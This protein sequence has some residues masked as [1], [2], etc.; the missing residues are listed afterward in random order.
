MHNE[1]APRHHTGAPGPF[2]YLKPRCEL[3]GS[4]AP[5][6][7]SPGSRSPS[8]AARSEFRGPPSARRPEIPGAWPRPGRRGRGPGGLA[9]VRR[10]ARAAKCYAPLSRGP[11]SRRPHDRLQAAS[12]MHP[13]RRALL[14]PRRGPPGRC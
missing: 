9:S 4:R 6:I 1:G 8:P 13:R 12:T 11:R 3:A 2:L 7:R 5:R 14:Q 10:D